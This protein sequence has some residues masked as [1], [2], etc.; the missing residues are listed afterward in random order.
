VWVQL[1][2]CAVLCRCFKKRWRVQCVG[3]GAG[4]CAVLCY[5]FEKGGRGYTL[6]FESVPCYAVAVLRG[7]A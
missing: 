1:H 3:V 7:E 6:G 2:L 5:C 4:V